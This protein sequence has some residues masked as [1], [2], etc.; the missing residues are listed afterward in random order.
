M[1]VYLD[2]D[3]VMADFDRH[4]KDYFDV[5]NKSMRDGKMWAMINSYPTFFRDLPVCDGALDL[6]EYANC[7]FD[8][9]ILTACPKSNYQSAALQKRQWVYEHLSPDVKVIPMLGG[10]NKGLFMHDEGDVLID[11][12]ESNCSAWDSLGGVS[13]LHE[14]F[15]KTHHI[16]SS[17]NA[18]FLFEEI[19]L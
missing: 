5:D 8:V 14:N 10:K 12:F 15:E 4:F 13:I 1:Q 2:L 19:V 17:W 9:T 18:S 11:D 6:F 16:L 3:G 7:T